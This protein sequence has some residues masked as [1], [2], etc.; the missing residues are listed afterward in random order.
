MPCCF[1]ASVVPGGIHRLVCWPASW[2]SVGALTPYGCVTVPLFVHA[3]G[4]NEL[5]WLWVACDAPHSIRVL[6][7]GDPVVVGA[8]WQS[9][10]LS[11]TTC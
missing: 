2:L 3:F 11:S 9:L 10:C 5:L 8:A 1:D 4:G 6:R 7:A